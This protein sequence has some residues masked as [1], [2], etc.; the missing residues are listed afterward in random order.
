MPSLGFFILTFEKN[1]F[2]ITPVFLKASRFAV[3]NMILLRLD[4]PLKPASE[5]VNI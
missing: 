4:I 2:I 1:T 3:L 5:L